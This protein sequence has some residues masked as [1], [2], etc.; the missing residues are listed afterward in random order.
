MYSVHVKACKDGC[1]LGSFWYKL[2]AEIKD[3]SESG[4]QESVA[5]YTVVPKFEARGLYNNQFEELSHL[6]PDGWGV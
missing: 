5:I 4:C 3:L 2:D 1:W 6:D